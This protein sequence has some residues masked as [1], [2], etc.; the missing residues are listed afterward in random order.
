MPHSGNGWPAA[1]RTQ[2][3]GKGDE[4]S[5]ATA[6][7]PT[8]DSITRAEFAQ[9]ADINILMARLGVDAPQRQMIYGEVDFDLDLQSAYAA[10]DKARE[11]LRAVPDELKEKYKSAAQVLNAVESGAY[12]QDLEQLEQKRAKD[13]TDK[14]RAERR[15]QLETDQ[16]IT[17]DMAAE[18]AA[19]AARAGNG[20]PDKTPKP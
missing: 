1:T 18:R 16:E 5:A 12:Q 15:R 4:V 20:A 6:T 13:R 7:E 2:V 19:A 9:D 3:D 8:G 11:V 14:L 10:A 17:A